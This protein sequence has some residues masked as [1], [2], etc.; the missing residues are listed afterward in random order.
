MLICLPGMPS[1]EKRAA[2]SATR[3]EPLVIT[4][5]WTIVTMEKI[6][7]PTTR[8]SPITNSPKEAMISPASAWLRIS[9]LVLI[10]SARRNRV[11]NSSNAGKVEKL[12]MRSM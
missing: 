1:S 10:D 9:R 5:N 7:K 11:V 8:L 6:T 12:R 3:S 2:T 4:M